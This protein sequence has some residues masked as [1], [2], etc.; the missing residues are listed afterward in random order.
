MFAFTVNCHG[1]YPSIVKHGVG[2]QMSLSPKQWQ[3]DGDVIQPRMT[4][5][6]D[7]QTHHTLTDRLNFEGLLEESSDDAAVAAA[8]ASKK[9]NADSDDQQNGP[10]KHQA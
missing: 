8:T 1:T 3:L 9:R 5:F 2:A 6:N 4:K 7:R 10:R